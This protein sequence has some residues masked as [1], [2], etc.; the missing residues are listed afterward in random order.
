MNLSPYVTNTNTTIPKTENSN[1]TLNNPLI[2][3]GTRNIFV[4]FTV[5]FPADNIFYNCYLVIKK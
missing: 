4:T 2:D 1:I 5:F 3:L